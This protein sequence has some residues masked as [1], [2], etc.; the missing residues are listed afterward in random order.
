MGK[1]D[2][3][4]DY[5]ARQAADEVRMT[6]AEVERL[7]GGLPD[8]ARVHRA[9]WAN[10]S[11]VEALAWREAGWHVSA[12]NQSAEVVVFARGAVGG[13]FRS[14]QVALS[15]R[16]SYVDPKVVDAIRMQTG[17]SRYDYGKL[18]RL[19]EELNDS[20]RRG[21]AYASLALLRAILDHVPPIFGC[22]DFSAV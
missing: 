13:S 7:V 22:A 5:L 3:L 10:D 21:N 2:P 6:F 4:R 8:S 17:R 11:K 12:V 20:Y 16:G 15:E 18:L 19:V 14:R 1:Y 9:W